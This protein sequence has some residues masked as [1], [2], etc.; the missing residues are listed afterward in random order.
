MPIDPTSTTP[1]LPQ[2]K[3]EPEKVHMKCRN[4]SCDSITAYV[5]KVPGQGAV[6][7]YRCTK[8]HATK[9]INVGGGIDI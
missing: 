2:S 3:D 5:I 7:L 6:R 1:G 9:A 4:P 8:C